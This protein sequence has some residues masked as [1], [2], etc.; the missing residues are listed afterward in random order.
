MRSLII[1]WRR[2]S[3]VS[4]AVFA[5]TWATRVV[6]QVDVPTEKLPSFTVESTRVANDEPAGT[7]A[8]PV[9]VLRYEPRIDVQ[10]RNFAEAQADVSVRGGLFEQTGVRLGAAA[11][12]DPQTGHYLFE[13]PVS[14]EMLSAP[15]VSTGADL[16]IT[17]FNAGA[18]LVGYDWAQIRPGGRVSIAGGP[19]GYHRESLYGA[20]TQEVSTQG[21][22]GADVAITRSQSDGAIAF[23]DHDFSRADGR[24]QWR[25]GQGQ[26]DLFA[27]YQHKFFGWPNLYTPFGFNESEDLQTVLALLN[28]TWRDSRGNEFSAA[29]FYRRNRDDYEF[30]RAVPGASNPFQHTTWLRGASVAGRVRGSDAVAVRYAFDVQSDF[31]ES[32]S[33]T[34]GHYNSRVISKGVL[35]PELTTSSTAGTLIARGGVTLDHSNRDGSAWSPIAEIEW[36]DRTEHVV[37]VEYS[38]STQLPSYTALNSNSGA[39]LFR[40]NPNLK[41]EQSRNL[42][43][44]AS[45]TSQGWQFESALFRRW[46]DQLVDWTY[47]RGVTARTANPVDTVTDGVEL[48]ASRR[49]ESLDLTIGYSWLE[50]SSSY[51]S[52]L[53]DASFYALNFPEH[54]AT[55]AVRWRMGRGFEL[56]A[57][58]EYRVQAPNFLRTAGGEHAWL[59]SLALHY[60]P[61]HWRGWEFAV[62]IDNLWD[63][64]FQEVPSVPAAPR[65]WAASV[66]KRW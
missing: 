52:A 50:K 55:A 13:L 23:G 59:T 26:T 3:R 10:A 64:D 2:V 12:S 44:S 8:T 7:M 40:G 66:A 32:T 63:S 6:A 1:L 37:R 35:T 51:G 45:F 31:L 30:N 19:N 58:N 17:G 22:L 27:G 46:D 49:S 4:L 57:D 34:F 24:V 61:P 25:A 53:V 56:R 5:I 65:Q 54:R 38:E 15:V 11:L 39:G 47:R 29:V 36:R 41:R 48:L 14:S 16:A 21:V 9:S 62:L 20:G 18:G 42:E 28:H 33:L 60:V 43:C